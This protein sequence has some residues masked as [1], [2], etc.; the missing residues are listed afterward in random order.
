MKRI[1]VQ[2]GVSVSTA[3]A[4]GAIVSA[5]AHNDASI[6]IR[7]VMAPTIPQAGTCLFTADPT[8]PSLSVGQADVSFP[9][10]ASYTPEILVGNQIIQQAN[11]NAVQAETSRVFIHGAI[12]RYTDLTGGTILDLLSNMCGQGSGDAAACATG[13]AIGGTLAAPHNPFSTFEAS[14]VE[15][16]NGPTPSYSVMGVTMIDGATVDILRS[17]F[18]ASIAVNGAA[19]YSTQIQLISYTKVEGITQGGD[20]IESN[21]FVF[22]IT[23]SYGA[24]IANPLVPDPAVPNVFACLAPVAVPLVQQTCVY[25]EDGAAIV[26]QVVVNV[27]QSSG[28][29]VPT[30]VPPCGSADAGAPVRDGG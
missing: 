9:G 5:C 24:L 1:W 16:A 17:Y 6:F 4:A 10:L 19:A 23:F 12:T 11:M 30:L 22:P 7:Q 26:G 14:S 28:P 25:G 8:Q 29:P 15:P 13:K 21:E 18:E 3:V 27:P 20:S 2:V